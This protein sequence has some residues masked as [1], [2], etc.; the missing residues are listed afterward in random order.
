MYNGVVNDMK[1]HDL[2]PR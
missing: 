2:F 1:C